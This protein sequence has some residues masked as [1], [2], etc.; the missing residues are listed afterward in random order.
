[1]GSAG[2]LLAV[3]AFYLLPLLLHE[4]DDNMY[5]LIWTCLEKCWLDGE[6]VGTMMGADD[7]MEFMAG[8]AQLVIT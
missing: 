5:E 4:R 1:M 8:E 7:L 2:K 3:V 6:W